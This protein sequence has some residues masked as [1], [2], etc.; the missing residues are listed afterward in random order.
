M[1]IGNLSVFVMLMV[2]VTVFSQRAV[3]KNVGDFKEI[4]VYDLIEVKL[5]KS[6]ENKVVVKGDNVDDIQIVNKNNTLKIKMALDKIFHGENTFV[7]VYFKE[8]R[9]IDGN[10]GAKISVNE[11]LVQDA[12]ELKAQEGASINVKMDVAQLSARSVT[13]GIIAT[14]G[15]TKN[16]S[17]ALNTG[18]VFEGKTLESGTVK[19]KITTGGSAEVFASERADI[20]IKAGGDVVVFGN[21]KEVN[22]NTFAG[23]RVK[24]ME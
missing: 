10:E 17:L 5:I 22:K 16:V 15:K 9:S 14:S 24:I 11:L 23:G 8:I 19:V 12:L 4:K 2:T 6:D 13:G 7:E 18:G 20:D 21:P 1:K 3:E